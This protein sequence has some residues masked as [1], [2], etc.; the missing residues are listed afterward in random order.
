MHRVCSFCF[1]LGVVAYLPI[2]GKHGSDSESYTQLG[3]FDAKRFDYIFDMYSS[4]PHTHLTFTEGVRMLHGNRNPFDPVR[5][6]YFNPTDL[7][8]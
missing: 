2:Q 8:Y 1:G 6:L 3:E 4:E 7:R 5:S